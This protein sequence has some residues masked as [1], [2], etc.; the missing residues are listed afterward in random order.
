MRSKQLLL[1]FIAISGLTACTSS[2][3]K[4]SIIGNI[5]GMPEQT[6][7]LEQLNAN[8]I[9]TIVDSER[10]KPDGHFELSGISPEPGLYRVHLHQ[11]KFILLSVDKGNIKVT[12]D[13]NS[14]ENY[15]VA[16]TVASEELK[17]FLASI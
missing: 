7:I 9:I 10:S 16:G 11:N 3:R 4:F 15:S 12:A 6:V 2:N 1:F 13:W 8:D 14:L 5:N 17:A